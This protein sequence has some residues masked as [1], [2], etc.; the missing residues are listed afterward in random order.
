MHLIALLV[1]MLVILQPL[2]VPA[3]ETDQYTLPVGREFADLGPHFSHMV[4]D[5]V[6]EAMNTTNAAIRHSLHDGRAT[7]RTLRLQSARVCEPYCAAVVPTSSTDTA[8]NAGG[9]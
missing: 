6:V 3:H 5:A 2:T 7:T 8:T 9:A 4:H 1:L